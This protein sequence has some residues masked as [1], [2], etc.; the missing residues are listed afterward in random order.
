MT[1]YS[2]LYTYTSGRIPPITLYYEQNKDTPRLYH[3]GVLS[4][5]L[6][7]PCHAMCAHEHCLAAC[8][9]ALARA[10]MVMALTSRREES[11]A[12]G[13]LANACVQAVNARLNCV[14]LP[15]LWSIPDRRLAL[16]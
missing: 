5:Y 16:K 1:L 4:L 13:A 12:R 2:D 3:C 10:E 11:A 15:G 6:G 7:L 9:R 8:D 14:N